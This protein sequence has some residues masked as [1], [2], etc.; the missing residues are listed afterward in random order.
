MLFQETPETVKQLKDTIT[1]FIVSGMVEIELLSKNSSKS[2]SSD[3]RMR[4]ACRDNT[5]THFLTRFV[6]ILHFLILVLCHFFPSFPQPASIVLL[7]LLTL[8]WANLKPKG[9]GVRCSR[10]FP[11]WSI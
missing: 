11:M 4:L 5:P 8:L 3:T 2:R 9:A 1:H 10:K 7:E 6:G